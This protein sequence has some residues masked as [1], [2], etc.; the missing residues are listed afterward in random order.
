MEPNGKREGRRRATLIHAEKERERERESLERERERRKVKEQVEDGEERERE[1]RGKIEGERNTQGKRQSE[2]SL[3]FRT[4]R[5]LLYFGSRMY[6]LMSQMN[7][8]REA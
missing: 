2:K 5:L 4:V 6:I 7:W 1:R 3:L 8:Q